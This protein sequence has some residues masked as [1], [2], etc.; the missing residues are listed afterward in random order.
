LEV[1]LHDLNRVVLDAGQL[2]E[3]APEPLN[4]LLRS[5]KAVFAEA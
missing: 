1:D 5:A 2:Q 4:P 3:L